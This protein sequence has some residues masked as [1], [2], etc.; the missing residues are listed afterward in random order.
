MRVIR[1]ALFLG[2]GFSLGYVKAMRDIP[3]IRGDVAILKD[4][5]V[6]LYEI[7]REDIAQRDAVR[8]DI[9]ALAE[10][11]TAAQ[12]EEPVVEEDDTTEQQGE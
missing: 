12:A 5:V 2:V 9:E 4:H 7:L 1:G 6:L 8:A 3:E 11:Q 10:Q